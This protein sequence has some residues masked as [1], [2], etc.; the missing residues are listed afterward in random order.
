MT[1]KTKNRPYLVDFKEY[2]GN[3]LKEDPEFRLHYL[4]SCLDE[5]SDPDLPEEEVLATL[6]CAI[7]AIIESYGSVDKF[8]KETN[9]NLSRKTLYNLVD[10]KS[11][12]RGPSVITLLRVFNAIGLSIMAQRA[13]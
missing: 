2:M 6:L 4:N 9:V 10:E 1:K 5:A 12:K 3:R 13:S 8:I 11:P 7:R